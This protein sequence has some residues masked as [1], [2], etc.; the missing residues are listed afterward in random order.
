MLSFYLQVVEF[1]LEIQAL[2][3][4]GFTQDHAEKAYIDNNLNLKEALKHLELKKQFLIYGFSE[5]KV[6]S[7]LLMHNNDSEMALEHLIS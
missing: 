5:D 6:T 3:E 7:A 2:E 4:K 1:L